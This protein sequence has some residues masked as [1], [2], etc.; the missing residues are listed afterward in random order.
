MSKNIWLLPT[1]KPSR[2]AKN[3]T[4]KFHFSDSNSESKLT[5]QNQNLYITNNEEIKEGD[6][7][8]TP[9]N[10]LRCAN[11]E[12][13]ITISQFI[14]K[15][16]FK[17]IILTTDQD[18]IKEG[19][20]EIPTDFL[21][22]FIKNP[23]CESVEV[24]SYITI[25]KNGIDEL[26]KDEFYQKHPDEL[27]NCVYINNYNL[28]IPQD[29]P[30][31]T[32]EELLKQSDEKDAIILED[33]SKWFKDRGVDLKKTI[34]EFALSEARKWVGENNN[35]K[36]ATYATAITVGANWQAGK[37]CSEE[38]VSHL[39]WIYDRLVTVHSENANYDYMLKFKDIIEKFKSNGQ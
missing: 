23:S 6:W 13:I 32:I 18:L 31:Q 21:E 26:M 7:F 15:N 4:G 34:E 17:K 16:D 11:K 38:E 8:L 12:W 9:T 36:I 27:P 35:H 14:P 25:K 10:D 33:N 37:M 39:E 5:S 29:Q 30:K 2:L 22:W 24:R 28:I 20:Q 3:T 1:D 19:I